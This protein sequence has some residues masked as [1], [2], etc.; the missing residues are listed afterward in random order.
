MRM[1]SDLEVAFNSQLTMELGAANSYLQISAWFT[2]QNLKG[3][4]SWMRQQA[5]EES[6]HALM[7]LD[8]ILDRGGEATIGQVP[9]P[10][11]SFSSPLAAFDS[12]LAQ[13]QTVTKAIH[14]LYRAAEQADD[15]SSIPFLLGF[16]TEQ[17][18]E[19]ATMS[20]IAD[21]LRLAEGQSGALFLLDNELGG[22]SGG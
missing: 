6:A 16:I 18:E 11:A 12:A 14:Q 19:E 9:A 7:F 5:T 21:R 22:R 1:P 3:M 10:A 4:A 8:F 17:I 2:T 20:A 13:E 15:I